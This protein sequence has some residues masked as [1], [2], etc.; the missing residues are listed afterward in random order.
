VSV[1]F[2]LPIGSLGLCCHNSGNAFP[3]RERSAER[4]REDLVPAEVDIVVNG[5]DAGEF[6]GLVDAF[7][8]QTEIGSLHFCSLHCVPMNGGARGQL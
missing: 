7:D 5:T 3:R 2:T 8:L 6:P 4:A 1:A